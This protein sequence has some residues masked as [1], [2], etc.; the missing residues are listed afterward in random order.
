MMTKNN[1]LKT[2]LVLFSFYFTT[3]C[4]ASFLRSVTFDDIRGEEGGVGSESLRTVSHI[5]A[6][7]VKLTPEEK[8]TLINSPYLNNVHSLYI[9]DQYLDENFILRLCQN[10]ALKRLINLEISKN[11]NIT[12]LSLQSILESDLGLIRD[13]PQ[14][15]GRYGIPSSTIY[16]TASKTSIVSKDNQR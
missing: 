15:S 6:S 9:L 5:Q 7:G 2:F 14:I 4:Q 3:S 13:L 12:N 1:F 11:Q 16:V 10:T 8:E